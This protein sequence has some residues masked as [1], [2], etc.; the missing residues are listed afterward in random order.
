MAHNMSSDEQD[1]IIPKNC[2]SYSTIHAFKGMEND[3]IILCGIKFLNTEED[4][5]V[6][7][8]GMTRVKAKLYIIYKAELEKQFRRS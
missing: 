2:C 5:S 3:V 1:L 6:L 7:Y 8:V 4:K